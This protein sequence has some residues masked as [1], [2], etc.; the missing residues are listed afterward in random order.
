LFDDDL[1][2]KPKVVQSLQNISKRKLSNLD[3]RLLRGFYTCE[4]KE[5]ALVNEIHSAS[6]DQKSAV[7][8]EAAPIEASPSLVKHPPPPG[9]FDQIVANDKDK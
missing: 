7:P 8:D 4:R 2:V 9:T 5:L 1:T 6:S 3:K